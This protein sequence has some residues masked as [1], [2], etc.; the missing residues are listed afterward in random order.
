MKYTQL[1]LKVNPVLGEAV[2]EFAASNDVTLNRAAVHL[3]T[4]GLKEMQKQHGGSVM[5]YLNN[6]S[7]KD[8]EVH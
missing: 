2:K 1:H 3:I 7:L 4:L 6:I 5:H 8:Q